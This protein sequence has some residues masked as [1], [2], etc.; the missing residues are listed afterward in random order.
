VWTPAELRPL[1]GQSN[2]APDR[3]ILAWS[4]FTWDPNRGDLLLY[5]GGHANYSGNDVYR[6]RGSTRQ[7][8]RAS[9]PSQIK[10]DDL[11]NFQAID[12]WDNAPGS[13][14]TYDTNSFFPHLDRM[15]VFGGAA[16]NSGS[17]F[18]REVTPTT[19]RTTGPFFF[20]PARADPNKVGGSTGSHVQRVAPHPEIV[21]GQMWA[22]RDVYVNIPNNP[23]LPGNFVNGCAAYAT[24]TARTS[25]T[26]ARG[27]RAAA[28]RCSCT[29]TRPMRSPVRRRIRCRWPACSGT[30][31]TTRPR[32]ASIRCASC[33]CA[34]ATPPCRSCTGT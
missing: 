15:V 6:W 25:P 16:Y 1:D 30:A 29:S 14:H 3:I 20:D 34:P 9:L 13:A 24:R 31:P 22:N 21:G 17:A 12:G 33:S 28:R 8:E 27:H 4:G 10:Q 11:G 18:M 2:P 19:A 5:G 32:A 7:W 23:S 26:W